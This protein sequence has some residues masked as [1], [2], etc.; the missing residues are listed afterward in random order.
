MISWWGK[1]LFWTLRGLLWVGAKLLF[2]LRT[3]GREHV[4]RS[5]PAIIAC[6]HVSHLDPPLVGLAVPRM[7]F[8]VAKKELL[9][10]A[11]LMWLMRS[12]GTIIVDRGQGRRGLEDSIAYLKRGAC[13]II[14]P[15]GTRSVN[16]K[17]AQGRSGAIVMALRAGCP[18]VPA[19]IIGTERALTKGSKAIKLV[20]VTVRFS[21]PYTV[22]YVGDTEKLPRDF[23]RRESF[24]L[25]ERIEALLP[26]HMKP[27][28]DDKSSWYGPLMN[29]GQTT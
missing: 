15:E 20:P 4:P 14:Y 7:I 27:S 12:I 24:A 9:S 25:M 19:A 23:L 2:R 26:P 8:H 29:G 17:L 22:A 10:L 5:G 11:P 21:E 1:L 18:I 28:R 3:E 6:N 13:V 16:G